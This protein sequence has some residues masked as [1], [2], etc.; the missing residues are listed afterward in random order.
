[1][2]AVI[3]S[4]F[5]TV[6]SLSTLH[7]ETP[8]SA[9]EKAAIHA[10]IR[11]YLLE[12]P[13]ILREAMAV[14]EEREAEAAAEA[15]I[16]LVQEHR[17][18]LLGDGFSYIG[19]NPEG[20]VTLIEFVDY[21]CGFCKRAHPEVQALIAADPNIRYIVKELPILGPA[22][23][24]AARAALA[25][26]DLQG[27]AAYAR[28]S[29]AL[30]RHEGQL[31]PGVITALADEAGADVD[32]MMALA[33]SDAITNRLNE[34]RALASA[35]KL[36]GTPTFVLGDRILRGYLPLQDMQAIVAETREGT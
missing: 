13:E 10:E 7:A 33:D 29:D 35:I 21:Q 17:A 15:D 31:T 9:D 24:A 4:L 1:M 22:S 30:M 2:K 26:L 34:T 5:V 20:D 18:A 19:G 11:A 6:L 32:E 23:M 27:D 14:L 25:V 12:N 36:S 3:L 16:A 28:F 8:L